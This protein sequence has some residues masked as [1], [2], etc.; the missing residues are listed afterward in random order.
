MFF[1]QL[2]EQAGWRI[3]PSHFAPG[4]PARDEFVAARFYSQ[5]TGDNERLAAVLGREIVPL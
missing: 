4:T 3:D 1:S 5:A 2:A